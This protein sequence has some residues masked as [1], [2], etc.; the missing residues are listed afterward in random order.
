MVPTPM[1]DLVETFAG[2][3][4]LCF[5]HTRQM[6]DHQNMYMTDSRNPYGSKMIKLNIKTGCKDRLF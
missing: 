1:E 2:N 4:Y 3:L 5:Q 6:V